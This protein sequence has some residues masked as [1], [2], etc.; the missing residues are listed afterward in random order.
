VTGEKIKYLC[1]AVLCAMINNVILIGGSELGISDTTGVMAAWL[2]GGTVGYLWHCLVS[3]RQALAPCGYGQ[4]MIGMLIGIPLTWLS[5]VF[6][7]HVVGWPMTF[8]SPA[9]TIVLF[10]YNYL[11]ARLAIVVRRQPDP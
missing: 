6:F 3:F 8:A 10:L 7:R 9:T 11:N 1:G 5:I 4:F 2:L